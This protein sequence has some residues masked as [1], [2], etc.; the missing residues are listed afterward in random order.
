[1]DSTP[2]PARAPSN[3]PTHAARAGGACE[4]LVGEI[5]WSASSTTPSMRRV[6]VREYMEV[7]VGKGGE[8]VFLIISL[9][10]AVD[11]EDDDEEEDEEDAAERLLRRCW[12]Y[13]MPRCTAL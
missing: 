12:R 7:G 3:A 5:R 11:D 13:G 4:V 10:C 2:V 8:F 6:R 1:M 9:Y